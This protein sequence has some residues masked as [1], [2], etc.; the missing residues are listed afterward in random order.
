MSL[1]VN[2]HFIS[3]EIPHTEQVKCMFC[4]LKQVHKTDKLTYPINLYNLE[5]M[6]NLSQP[7]FTFKRQ[8][9]CVNYDRL[10]DKDKN[11]KVFVS[12]ISFSDFHLV[13]S[14]A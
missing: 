9:Y 3:C 7:Y 6:Q 1:D 10:G 4:C 8:I 14:T 13:S 11:L 12:G 2:P 5:K